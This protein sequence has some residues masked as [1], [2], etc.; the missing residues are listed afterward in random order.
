MTGRPRPDLAG[1]VVLLL[2]AALAL[3]M[4]IAFADIAVR[5]FSLGAEGVDLVSALT[6]GILGVIATFV[7]LRANRSKDERP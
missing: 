1:L 2:T 4:V 3:C 6:G 5:G 7:G